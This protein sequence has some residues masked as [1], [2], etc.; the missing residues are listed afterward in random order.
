MKATTTPSR[1]A[2]SNPALAEATANALSK[3]HGKDVAPAAKAKR[4]SNRDKAA[5]KGVTKATKDWSSLGK[6]DATKVNTADVEADK[7]RCETLSFRLPQF[8]STG[9]KPVSGKQKTRQFVDEVE[10]Y[11]KGWK[12]YQGSLAIGV[13]KSFQTR[14]SEARRVCHAYILRFSETGQAGV[15]SITAILNGPG[16]YHAKINALP[17]MQTNP[18]ASGT[19]TNKAHKGPT[20]L[21]E[22]EKA[23][24]TQRV[25]T[26]AKFT[27]RDLGDVAAHSTDA[28]L[29]VLCQAVAI[30]C[31]AS[32]DATFQQ[33]GKTIAELLASAK[34]ADAVP[35]QEIQQQA[36]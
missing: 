13:Q 12:D 31:Q 20:A 27:E 15:D 30:R 25:A 7:V 35:K 28:Q 6:L 33:I 8:A 2:A 11:F 21:T 1:R 16:G 4:Q 9:F 5:G 32:K 10:T 22:L 34:R 23:E 26:V 19:R 18:T 29:Q 3:Q 36:A 24:Q 17:T 14:I